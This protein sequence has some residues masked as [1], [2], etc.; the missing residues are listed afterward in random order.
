VFSKKS[1]SGVFTK[2]AI[3]I[4]D[5]KKRAILSDMA[6]KQDIKK[7]IPQDAEV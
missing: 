5:A 6:H 4:S 3:D 1:N 7:I 2:Q